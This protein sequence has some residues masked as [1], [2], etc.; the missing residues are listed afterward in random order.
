MVSVGFRASRAAGLTLLEVVIALAILAILGATFSTAML[1]N[2]NHSNTAGQRTQAAQV[3]NYLGRRV[4]GGDAELL[5]QLGESLTWE[6]GELGDTFQDLRS[7]QGL[8]DPSRY[9]AEIAGSGTISVTGATL[10]Q[11]DMSVC[12][13][14][15]ESESC[16]R[17]TTIGAPVNAPPD[18]TPPLPG[19]N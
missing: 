15:Q 10:V 13:Q 4:A 16:V 19:I 7:N 1:G 2:L 18:A 14:A 9:R 6:Y 17:G 3:L 12:F 8:A 11:Y 5:P